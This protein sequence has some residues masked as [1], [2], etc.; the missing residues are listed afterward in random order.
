[1]FQL[2]QNVNFYFHFIVFKKLI[3]FHYF[4]N[5]PLQEHL[6]TTWLLSVEHRLREAKFH[7]VKAHARIWGLNSH[8]FVS[9]FFFNLLFHIDST[10]I[11][12]EFYLC[13]AGKHEK[14]CWNQK[15]VFDFSQFDC[16]NSTHLK[17]RIMDTELFTNGGFVGEAK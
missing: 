8:F 6:P 10:N 16:K 5:Q 4:F 11:G 14:P 12:S 9:F 2:M 15:F 3:I 1:M 7:Q 17:C 13:D